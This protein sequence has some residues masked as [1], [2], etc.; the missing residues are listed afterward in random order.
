MSGWYRSHNSLYSSDCFIFM[1]KF[2]VMATPTANFL[3]ICSQSKPPTLLRDEY[4]QW[5]IQMTLF[6]GGIHKDL[7]QYL[8]NPPFIPTV[9]GPWVPATANIEEVAERSPRKLRIGRQ[10]IRKSMSSLLSAKDFSLW[11]FL[12]TFLS[13]WMLV[14]HQNISGQNY[15]YN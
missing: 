9:V 10:R 13:F 2:P 7:P 8:H 12:M 6:L 3:N 1:S 11:L 5:K 4:P 14:I 15:K